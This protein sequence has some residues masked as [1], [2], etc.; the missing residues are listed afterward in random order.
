MQYISAIGSHLQLSQ[1]LENES[2][3]GLIDR[4][5]KRNIMSEMSFMLRLTILNKLKLFFAKINELIMESSETDNGKL[6]IFIKKKIEKL[7]NH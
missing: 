3:I 7:S 4:C 1:M 5:I 2:E 6:N